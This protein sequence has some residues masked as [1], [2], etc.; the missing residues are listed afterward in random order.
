MVGRYVVTYNGKKEDDNAAS[1]DADAAMCVYVFLLMAGA[2]T[3]ETKGVK[4]NRESIIL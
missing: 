1:G 2:T 3:Q 4:A